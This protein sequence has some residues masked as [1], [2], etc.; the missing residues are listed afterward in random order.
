MQR[1]L[2][3]RKRT[4]EDTAVSQVRRL[5]RRDSFPLTG[6]TCCASACMSCPH[7]AVVRTR[8]FMSGHGAIAYAVR[9]CRRR[10]L[11]SSYNVVLLLKHGLLG[12]NMLLFAICNHERS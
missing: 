7:T 1:W 2:P 6:V 4:Q 5:Y 10:T 11:R 8:K 3:R 12:R 9:S